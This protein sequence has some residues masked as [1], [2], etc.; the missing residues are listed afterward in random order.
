MDFFP[1][2][3][4][5]GNGFYKARCIFHDDHNPS[6]WIDPEN[7]I[8]NCHTCGFEKPLDVIN[9]FAYLHNLDEAQAIRELKKRL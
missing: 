6:L 5:S 2:A 3:Q 9:V 1:D 7:Q 4:P 8:C